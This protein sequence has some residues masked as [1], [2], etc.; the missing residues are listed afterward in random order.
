MLFQSDDQFVSRD[1]PDRLLLR[2]H[3]LHFDQ[4][5]RGGRLLHG[6]R[7]RRS[8]V[9]GSVITLVNHIL[10]RE[11]PEIPGAVLDARERSDRHWHGDHFLLH[12]QRPAQYRQRAEILELVSITFVLRHSDLCSRRHRRCKYDLKFIRWLGTSDF[13]IQ[14]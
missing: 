2:V 5:E 1:R 8:V 3:R 6:N 12:F 9:H 4:R 10:A 7:S 11:E 14:Y 13:L